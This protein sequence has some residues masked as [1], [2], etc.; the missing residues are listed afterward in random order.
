MSESKIVD[1]RSG[2]VMDMAYLDTW[3]KEELI[4]EVKNLT[5]L[6]MLASRTA[7]SGKQGGTK[8]GSTKIQCPYCDKWGELDFT[9][10]Y[11]KGHVLLQLESARGCEHLEAYDARTT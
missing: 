1:P 6:Y 7:M 11:K 3:S 9:G 5:K 8:V 10:E 4:A 2:D